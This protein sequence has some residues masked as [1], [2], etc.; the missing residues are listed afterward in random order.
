MSLEL[1][2]RELSALTIFALKNCDLEVLQSFPALTSHLQ[3]CTMPEEVVPLLRLEIDGLKRP[4]YINR[5]YGR[6]RKLLPHR[7]YEYLY[8]ITGVQFNGQERESD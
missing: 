8:R 7:D 5:M 4:A 3:K 1:E 2:M 6:Y